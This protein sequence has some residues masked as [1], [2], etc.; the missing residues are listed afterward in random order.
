[1]RRVRTNRPFL[2]TPGLHLPGQTLSQ[3]NNSTP[4]KPHFFLEKKRLPERIGFYA[5][6]LSLMLRGSWREKQNHLQRVASNQPPPGASP[7][8]A[9]PATA[10]L[11]HMAL[12][13]G[14]RPRSGHGSGP[15]PSD[16]WRSL[17]RGHRTYHGSSRA[18]VSRASDSWGGTWPHRPSAWPPVWSVPGS[19][20]T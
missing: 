18:G 16:P 6:F 20:G 11:R 12:G 15:S 10:R 5:P 14:G 9:S 8:P 3:D 2:V 17:Q 4:Q 7:S 19:R 1:M 13:P